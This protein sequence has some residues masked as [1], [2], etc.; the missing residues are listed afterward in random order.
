MPPR[1]KQA[2]RRAARDA[3]RSRSG[4]RTN[5]RAGDR[6][7]G[8]AWFDAIAGA[9]GTVVHVAEVSGDDWVAQELKVRFDRPVVIF[10]EPQWTFRHSAHNFELIESRTE[11]RSDQEDPEAVLRLE[12]QQ[13]RQEATDKQAFLEAAQLIVASRAVATDLE[14][15]RMQLEDLCGLR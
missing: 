12:V 14:R 3:T 11:L 4:G 10:G 5:F 6:V 2:A 8:A 1:A 9:V 15:A 7:R 13:L